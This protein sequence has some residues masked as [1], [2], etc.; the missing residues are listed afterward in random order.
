MTRN[1]A[2]IL[3]G[4]L[5]ACVLLLI[6]LEV[7]A[8]LLHGMLFGV[9]YT[10]DLVDEALGRGSEDVFFDATGF[11]SFYGEYLPHPYLGYSADPLSLSPFGG[12]RTSRFGFPGAD[13]ELRRSEQDR[14]VVITGGSV[15]LNL[16]GTSAALL[17][18]QLTSLARFTDYNV[19][20]VC[21][22]LPGFKQPQQLMTLN[23]FLAQ[24]AQFD[25]LI[26]L[27]GFNDITQ[28]LITNRPIGLALI[29]PGTW[30]ALAGA[31]P[32]TASLLLFANILQ[33]Q[34]QR[35]DS[36]ST[37]ATSPFRNSAFLFSVWKGLDRRLERETYGLRERWTALAL[38][39]PKTPLGAGP[40][41]ESEPLDPAQALREAVDIW[42]ASSLQMAYLC[43]GNGIPYFHFL[44]PNQYVPKSKVMSEEER[45][46]AIQKG[47][48]QN[49][50]REGY[51]LLIE[52]GRRLREKGVHFEE[53]TR[54][55]ED[56]S[57]SIYVDNCCHVNEEGSDIMAMYI[58][59]TIVRELRDP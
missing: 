58:A 41:F 14:V 57:E 28:P 5:F 48:Y 16:Y 54:V 53:M 11:T 3:S 33:L 34:E 56:I 55:F 27:D 24:N 35:R 50:V 51:P 4:T 39:R 6:S 22:A 19:R 40:S 8:R 52:A 9:A 42:S 30:R 10:K 20:I 26:N 45:R 25:L 13:M 12:R 29:Y 37:L 17:A 18:Q 44:Q 7:G 47:P 59:Q 2:K 49:I 46:I 36:R 32:D 21:L 38:E 1:V 23:Y 15:A 31:V 43:K